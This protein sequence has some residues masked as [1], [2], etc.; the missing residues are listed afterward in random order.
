M[1]KGDPV[2]IERK[3]TLYEVGDRS[4]RRK[5]AEFTV[6]DGLLRIRQFGFG[7]RPMDLKEAIDALQEL[8]LGRRS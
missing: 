3:I 4:E 1:V 7:N 5:A 6:E 2:K 8:E